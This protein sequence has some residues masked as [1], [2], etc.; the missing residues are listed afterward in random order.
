MRCFH[1][2]SC[3]PRPTGQPRRRIAGAPAGSGR[4]PDEGDEPL[5]VSDC[6]DVLGLAKGDSARV[7][8]DCDRL[9][10][11][12]CLERD[13]L[14]DAGRRLGHVGLAIIRG[15]ADAP[16]GVGDSSLQEARSDNTAHTITPAGMARRMSTSMW[17]RTGGRRPR[18]SRLPG[19]FLVELP[20]EA[21]QPSAW[22]K[23]GVGATVARTS[24]HHCRTSSAHW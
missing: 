7:S 20:A 22:R 23:T 10:D 11:L 21:R 17:R 5:H 3:S 13:H 24:Q 12:S 6:G 9:S 8:T 14:D 19:G 4:L 1:P 18:Y 15:D 2:S 16:V